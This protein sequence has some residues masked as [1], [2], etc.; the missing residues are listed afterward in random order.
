MW[1]ACSALVGKK[2]GV[3]FG[4]N[5]SFNAVKKWHT[6]F[7]NYNY[8][9]IDLPTNLLV[10]QYMSN[11]VAKHWSLKYL[12]LQSPHQALLHANQRSSACPEWQTWAGQSLLSCCWCCYCPDSGWPQSSLC[13]DKQIYYSADWQ[14]TLKL[15]HLNLKCIGVIM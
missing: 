6:Q 14:R 15:A 3:L 12:Y 11:Y 2:T 10:Y 7:K 1:A 9:F 5:V 8:S 4:V 13:S